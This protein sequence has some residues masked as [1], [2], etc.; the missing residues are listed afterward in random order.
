MSQ[1]MRTEP[2]ALAS[3]RLSRAL[4]PY[5]PDDVR[6]V[7]TAEENEKLLDAVAREQIITLY[8]QQVGAG[9]AEAAIVGDF[10]PEPA[11]AQVREI[12]KD[13]KSQVPVKRIERAAPTELKG[14]REEILTP[15]NINAVYAAGLAFPLKESDPEYA[16]LRLG[17][18]IFG[19]GTLSS[20]LG[21]RIR[22]KEG[23]S[24]GVTSQFTASALDPLATFTVNASTNPVNI[25]RV[26]KAV[27]EELTEFLANGPSLNEL[28]DAQ[29]AYLEAQKVS[30]TSDAAIAGQIAGNLHLG[31][32]FAHATEL[33]KRIGSLTPEDVK[34]AFR[35]YVDPKKLVI[36]RAGDFAR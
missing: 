10:D 13:W 26:D 23:L 28:L 1:M 35:K 20:R 27:A 21:N 2:A 32:T 33:E 7:P 15:D 4:S 29:K 8:D 6:Y 22:Q 16:A 17:N 14:V 30:R 19:G 25:D 3:N 24:Y 5:P 9:E 12:L 11:L 36:I 18:F 34:T 31:R